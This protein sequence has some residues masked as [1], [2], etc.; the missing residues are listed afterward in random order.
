VKRGERQGYVVSSDKNVLPYCSKTRTS[1][2]FRSGN[3]AHALSAASS[4]QKSFIVVGSFFGENV[5][6]CS[7]VRSNVSEF[8]YCKFVH[9]D[10]CVTHPFYFADYSCHSNSSFRSIPLSCFRINPAAIDEYD[11]PVISSERRLCVIRAGDA[12]G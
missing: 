11:C 1:L 12:A 10:G 3:C 7:Q 8:D 9:R 4:T 5:F 2:S 6:F